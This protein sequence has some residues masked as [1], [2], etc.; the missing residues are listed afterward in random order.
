MLT[1]NYEVVYSARRTISLC[2][3]G[4]KVIV[5]AP[6][7]I[8]NKKIY[9]LVEKHNAWIEKHIAE[10]SVRAKQNEALEAREGE[11]RLLAREILPQKTEMYAR[12]M[13][14]S[15]GKITITGAKGRFGSCSSK[16]N[17]SYS[18]RLM[19]YPE[20]AIDYVVVHELAHLFEMNHSPAFYRHVERILPDYKER[21]LLLKTKGIV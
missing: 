6:Y 16:G 15:Y 17:I 21:R 7:G 4:E 18:F 11:L 9:R 2:I 10:Q 8:S 3:K 20:E 5:R 12:Q 19:G 13:G 1:R 14:V